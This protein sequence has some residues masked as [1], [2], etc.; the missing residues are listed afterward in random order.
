MVIIIS[1]EKCTEYSEKDHPE[2]PRRIVESADLLKREGFKFVEAKPA[3][4]DDILKTHSADYVEKLKA[5][6]FQEFETP[7]HENIY[8]YAL[9]AAGAAIQATE[10]AMKGEPAFSLMRPPGHHAGNKVMGFCYLNNAAIAGFYAQSKGVKKVAVLDIDFHHGNGT[11]EILMGKEGFLHVDLHAYPAWPMSGLKSEQNCINI[12]VGRNSEQNYLV[13]LDKGIR[14]IQ[15]F[16]PELLIVSAGFDT[17]D[18]DPVGSLGLKVETFFDIGKKISGLCKSENIK[19]GSI[20]EGGYSSALPECI[21]NYLKGL[22]S[23]K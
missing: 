12:L 8:E 9:L 5:L 4:I 20:L 13:K 16:A 22:E 10:Y 11:Q 23:I 18:G 6:D 2:S 15:R 7:N 3:R 21:S 19:S 14:I 1:S 17:Y